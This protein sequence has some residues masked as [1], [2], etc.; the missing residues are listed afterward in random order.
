MTLLPRALQWRLTETLPELTL[1]WLLH[2]WQLFQM[3]ELCSH[4][5]R[6]S[7]SMERL[8]ICRVRPPRCCAK[9]KRSGLAGMDRVLGM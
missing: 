5:L 7:C 2:A 9:G 6:K 4:D 3:A 8:G 1:V